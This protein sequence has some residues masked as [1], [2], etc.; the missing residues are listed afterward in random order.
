MNEK[1]KRLA[2]KVVGL[3]REGEFSSPQQC[4]DLFRDIYNKQYDYFQT[5]SPDAIIKLVLY[6][7]SL[8]N[9]GNFQL[10][11]NMLNRLGFA[12]LFITQGDYHEETC[13]YC[14]G[15]GYYTCE[16]C[17]S[18]GNVSCDTCNAS[19]EVDCP[20]CEG[21]RSFEVGDNEW[22]DCEEC[23]GRGKVD[24]DNCG[25]DGEVICDNCS[26]HGTNECE[27]CNG[28]GSLETSELNYEYYVIATWN[29]DI[30]N[31]CELR[32]GTTE[33]ILS[34]Y[35]ID[36]LRDEYIILGSDEDH[37]EF[38]SFVESNE[39]Y[40]T[41]YED[42]PELNKSYSKFLN[43]WTEDNKMNRYTL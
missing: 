13:E 34:E 19:G 6:V 40:C 30:K 10:A 7:Y 23:S 18:S 24:C 37:A 2:S 35:D 8:R 9:T 11:E 41:N 27:H 42:E 25:G 29:N 16:E 31:A 20:E 4:Y 28:S 43:I 32:A 26:G 39:Y 3:F 36:R 22:E 5:L 1:L 17:G 12:S 33:P 38:R 14:N 15:D 21:E